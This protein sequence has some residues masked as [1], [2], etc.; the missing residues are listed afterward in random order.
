M[1]M[2]LTPRERILLVASVAFLAVWAAFALAVRPAMTRIETLERIIPQK[3]SELAT[4]RAKSE[5][6]AILRSNLDDVR[7]KLTSQEAAFELL[8]FLESLIGR[9]G[10]TQNMVKMKPHTV[11]LGSDYRETIVEIKLENLALAQLVN[12][13]SKVK[14]ATALVRTRTL[15]IKK[16]PTKTDLLDCTIEVHNAQ[17]IQS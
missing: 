11:P 17:L 15:H 4:L 3:Q 2:R 1:M 6:Y 12:F 16:S 13:L 8:P 7:A 5:Q 14:S 10:L 9:C